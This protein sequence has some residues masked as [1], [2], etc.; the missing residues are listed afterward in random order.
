MWSMQLVGRQKGALTNT[1]RGRPSRNGNPPSS[2]TEGVVCR[3]LTRCAPFS[4]CRYLVNHPLV[5]L[6]IS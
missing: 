1:R 3:C 4:S 6:S 5:G 2:A